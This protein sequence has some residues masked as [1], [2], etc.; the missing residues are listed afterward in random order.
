M[1]LPLTPL[2]PVNGPS[3]ASLDPSLAYSSTAFSKALSLNPNLAS[4][5]VGE[6]STGGV[7]PL[8]G[9]AG[10]ALNPTGPATHSTAEMQKV[11]KQFEAIFLRMML[12]EMKAT[13]EKN[14][15]FGN[16]RAMEMFESMKD[17]N[18]ADRL[19]EQGIGLGN[20][21][22]RQLLDN[23]VKNNQKASGS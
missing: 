14:P 21:V 6:V 16:S 8:G 22:Y 15:L 1:S 4:Q 7:I 2:M 20:L 9:K 18:L 13:V 10:I 11:A 17:D 19:S 3:A 5:A 23:A 12:K